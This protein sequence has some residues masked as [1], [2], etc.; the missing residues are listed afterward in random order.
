V[1]LKPARISGQLAKATCALLGA[2]TLQAVEATEAAPWEIDSAFLYY[3]ESGRV[4]V[5]EPVVNLRKEVADDNIINLRVVLDSLTGASAN[6]AIP[7]D[8]PQTFTTPS[9]EGTYTSAAH[10][11]PLDHSFS[12]IR[13]A[14]DL[15]WETPFAALSKTLWSASFSREYDYMAYSLA[16]NLSQDFN[17]R[18]T[19]VTAA[20]SYGKDYSK[21]IGGAP[22][23]LS[24]MPSTTAT[25]KSQLPGQQSKTIKDVFLGL[26]QII[27][28]RTLVQ[29]NVGFGNSR[30][31]MTDPYKILSVVDLSANTTGYVFEN[32]PDKRHKRVVYGN[33]I[34]QLNT[35]VIR[36]SYRYYK[37]DWDIKSHT[38]EFRYR[39]EIG[40][41]HFLQPH[42]RYYQQN[43]ARF[44]RYFLRDSD[45]PQYASADYRLNAMSG[46]TF[47]LLYGI[48]VKPLSEFSIRL[49]KY[50]Q[51]GEGQPNAAF[52]KIRDQ[53]LFP[54]VETWIFQLGY[55]FTF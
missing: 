2:N 55:S 44:H 47:G 6:G 40:H 32:R 41:G 26:S 13:G 8:T 23:G 43:A 35:D 3:T 48:E 45:N 49:E 39:Y 52:G 25:A 37:D 27:D 31:Y 38:T 14:L 16:A 30:G 51:S 33:Y 22:V 5:Y 53:N 54:T 36:F 15:S 10:Q 17:N 24:A 9:G 21:P 18:N 7:T 50:L 19:T 12:D 42:L 11:L 20:F 46:R 34:H 1:Q 29:L 4:T 28:R